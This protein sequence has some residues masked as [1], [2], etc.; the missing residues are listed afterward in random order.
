MKEAAF[1]CRVRINVE[2]LP[3][4]IKEHAAESLGCAMVRA[5]RSEGCELGVLKG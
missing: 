4:R 2:S 5:Q 3:L 1:G